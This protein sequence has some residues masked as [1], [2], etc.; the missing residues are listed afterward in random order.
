MNQ[1]VDFSYY[2]DFLT[3][4]QPYSKWK[5]LIKYYTNHSNSMLDIGCGTGNLTSIIEHFDQV[6]GMDLSID[7]L[8]VAAQKSDKVRWLEGDMTDFSLNQ[9]FDLITI[10][11]DALNYLPDLNDVAVSFKN[12][13]EHLSN[14][15]IFIFDVHTEYK[16]NT[17][18]NNRS[19]IEDY[20]ELFLAW[21][22]IK[23]EEELSVWHE[24]S[25]FIKD[26]KDS[27]Q[28]VDESHYQRT[29]SKETYQ[30]LLEQQGFSILKVFTDFEPCSLNLKGD[31]LFF[32]AKK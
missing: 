3:Q 7:M 29:F 15:G 10:L 27:Y 5:E 17:W 31:R 28:R 26:D 18:F 23:G 14:D 30:Y 21:E 12:V 6:Y 9:E 4:D 22:A 25:F 24:L 32:V 8:T 13:Y 1:Y 19:Y 20:D 16:M 11:C 2:Y